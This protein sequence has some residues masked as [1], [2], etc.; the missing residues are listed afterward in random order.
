MHNSVK[1]IAHDSVP[2]VNVPVETHEHAK[3]SRPYAA[4]RNFFSSSS[5]EAASPEGF[6]VES[7]PPNSSLGAHFHDV[8]QF[9]VFFP[10]EGAWYQR[11]SIVRTMVHYADAYTTYGPFG[12][13][14]DDLSFYTLRAQPAKV[15]AHMPGSR[16]KLVEGGLRRNMHTEVPEPDGVESPTGAGRPLFLG[17]NDAMGA[18]LIRAE[19]QG[20]VPCP[21]SAG[22][23][24]QYYVVLSGSIRWGD[25]DLGPESV[26][27]VDADAPSPSLQVVGDSI[28]EVLVLQFPIARVRALASV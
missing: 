25:L 24:G 3:F 13:G 15:S 20:T 8:D 21:S 9:Q 18:F 11:S 5:E 26:G 4:V 28:A 10:S 14:A 17:E 6:L 7:F 22:T 19:P 1:F 2:L 16:D 27:W 12:S 23:G